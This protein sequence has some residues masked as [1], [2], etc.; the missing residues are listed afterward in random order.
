MFILSGLATG[1]ISGFMATYIFWYAMT[2]WLT[3]KIAF[4]PFIRKKESSKT[5]SRYSYLF[6]IVNLKN[7][8]SA[9]DIKIR[10][11][12][13]YPEISKPK[14]TNVYQIPLNTT[15]LM[16]LLPQDY[17]YDEYDDIDES[18]NEDE[19]KSTMKGRMIKLLINSENFRNIHQRK[20]FTEQINDHA[21]EDKLTLEELLAVSEKVFVRLYVSAS[22]NFSNS[23]KLFKKEYR[24]KDIVESEGYGI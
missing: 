12:I 15:N 3:P 2:H 1:F 5:P 8:T 16:E 7:K 4:S 22:D 19:F 6:K 18:S 23:R 24:L 14:F 13:H 10:A 9:I 21:K 20:F 17:D 11:V